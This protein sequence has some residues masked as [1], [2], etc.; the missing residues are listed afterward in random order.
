LSAL[1]ASSTGRWE[2]GKQN[3]RPDECDHVGEITD[4]KGPAAAEMVDEDDAEKFSEESNDGVDGLVTE[5][6]R[7]SDANFGLCF[8]SM[9]GEKGRRFVRR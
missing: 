9:S 1:I 6:V 4:N 2:L 3:G 5:G 8:V 7:P